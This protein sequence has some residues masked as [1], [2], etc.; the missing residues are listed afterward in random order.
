MNTSNET[1]HLHSI[2]VL[3]R[4]S[5]IIGYYLITLVSTIGLILNLLSIKLLMHKTLT[6]KFYKY[7]RCKSI[8]DS[9]VCLFGVGYLKNNCLLCIKNHLNSYGILFFQIHVIRIPFRSAL[10]ASTLSEVYLNLNRIYS[11]S[12][13]KTCLNNIQAKYFITFIVATCLFLDGISYFTVEIKESNQTGIYYSIL[14]D[15]G[16]SHFYKSYVLLILLLESV[17]PT[18]LLIVSNIIILIKFK[19][20]MSKKMTLNIQ[21]RDLIKKSEIKFTKMIL[22]LTGVFVCVKTLDMLSTIAF[23]YA[24]FFNQNISLLNKSLIDL[25]RQLS[26]LLV[27]MQYVLNIFIYVAID[28]NLLRIVNGIL[29]F[30]K[31]NIDFFFVYFKNFTLIKN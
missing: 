16:K 8:F 20:R 21:S 14:T 7:L 17:V 6:H 4:F 26:Y 27:F 24:S 23:R 15:F 25:F 22:A 13:V 30:N 1:I 10:L 12:N 2:K 3:E 18:V 19:R 28:P 31:V 29:D 5:D 9:I 11:F